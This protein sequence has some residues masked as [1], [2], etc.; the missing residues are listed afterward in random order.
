MRIDE[1][2]LKV[3]PNALSPMQASLKYSELLGGEGRRADCNLKYFL[4]DY[5]QDFLIIN[6]LAKK[7][8]QGI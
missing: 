7:C 2:L 8:P 5:E 3:G 1:R 6:L 4:Q